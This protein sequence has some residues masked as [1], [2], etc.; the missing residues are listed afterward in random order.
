MINVETEAARLDASGRVLA[1]PAVQ[2]VP[3]N[4]GRAECRLLQCRAECRLLLCARGDDQATVPIIF[5]NDARD[6]IRIVMARPSREHGPTS[7]GCSTTF[8]HAS[9]QPTTTELHTVR[10][11][12]RH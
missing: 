6:V 11:Y 1:P 5:S 8:M 9:K 4:L 7:F 10:L 3:D 2:R 12:I